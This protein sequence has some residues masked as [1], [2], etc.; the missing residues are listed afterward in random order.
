MKNTFGNSVAVTIYGESH[1]AAIGAVIDGLAPGIEVDEEFIRVL[2]EKR[3]GESNVST[4][5][6][7][8]DAFKI[9]SGVFEGKTAGTPISIII[10]N[11]DTKSKDYSK[12]KDLARPGHA[13][14]TAFCKYHGFQDYR[15]GGHFSGRISAPIV[16]AGAIAIK[17]LESKGI[18]IATH[19]L[20][21][22]D[23]CDRH[24]DPNNF[25]EDYDLLSTLSLPVLDLKA[26][27]EIENLIVEMRNEGDSVGG[28]L[29]TVVTGVPSG[30][31]EPWFDSVESLLAHALFSVPAVKGVEFGAGFEFA[32][33]KGSKANDPF[34]MKDERVV[35]ST[36]NNGGI[37]GGITN[38]MPIVFNCAVKPTPSIYKQ[39]KTVDFVKNE[40]ADLIINGRHDPAIVHRAAVVVTSMTALTLCDMLSQR[41]GTDYFCPLQQE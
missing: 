26:R 24:I 8:K 21:C 30:V 10:E 40:N 29:E 7:E 6:R 32:K 1:G 34:E 4:A 18:Y 36:N 12:T 35:S 38:A 3:K 5:R 37:N 23:V 39:Q 27:E 33:M 14:Y 13:D 28:R 25:K 20:S 22:G 9:V 31:G 19:V 16:A 11:E 41:F 17:A 2:L 15:G